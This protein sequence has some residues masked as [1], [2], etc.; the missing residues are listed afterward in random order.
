MTI[1][2]GSHV[3]SIKSTN[4]QLTEGPINLV[5]IKTTWTSYDKNQTIREKNK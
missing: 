2:D 1:F 5:F 3:I 4:D